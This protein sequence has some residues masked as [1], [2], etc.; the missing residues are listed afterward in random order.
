[1]PLQRFGALVEI[2]I[3]SGFPT[4]VLLM[5][6][7][8]GFGLPALTDDG[9]LSPPFVFTVS[10]LDAAVVVGLVL[11]F[12]RAHHESAGAVL[13]SDVELLPLSLEAEDDASA[14]LRGPLPSLP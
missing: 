10:L 13:L 1:M 11:M 7:L 8:R 5:V 4:Q 14:F 9:T 2:L 6:A 3:C 12:L